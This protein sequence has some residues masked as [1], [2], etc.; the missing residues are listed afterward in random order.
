M[1]SPPAVTLTCSTSQCCSCP[2]RQLST[3]TDQVSADP[4]AGTPAEHACVD[5]ACVDASAAL[6]PQT[7]VEL[8][9]QTVARKMIITQISSQQQSPSLLHWSHMMS[10]VVQQLAQL[11]YP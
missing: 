6:S 5:G 1:C 7:V 11:L 10:T 8:F 4:F 3:P 9:Y 2:T